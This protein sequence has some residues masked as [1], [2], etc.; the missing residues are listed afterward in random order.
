[1][2]H[3]Q[4]GMDIRLKTAKYTFDGQEMTLCCNM[5]VLAD[6][7]E[8][9]GGNLSNALN[10]ATTKTVMCF[11]TAMINDYLD[12]EGSDKSYT[13]KQVGRLIPPSKLT[14]ITSLVIE[15]TTAALRGDEE[16]EPK[17][18]NATRKTNP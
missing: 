13:V 3:K 12:S 11:L 15:L 6:V 8:A 4:S 10:N 14:E 18:A 17:N 9:F 16:P 7:Q 1:M 2:R 5:N